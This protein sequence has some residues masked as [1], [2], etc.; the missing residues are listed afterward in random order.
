MIEATT[1]LVIW[2]ELV[3]SKEPTSRRIFLVNTPINYPPMVDKINKVAFWNI[4]FIR[5]QLCYTA[6]AE[7]ISF[8][9]DSCSHLQVQTVP[10]STCGAPCPVVTP[11][12]HY[13]L[14]SALSAI[15]RLL[16]DCFTTHNLSETASISAPLM[17]SSLIIQ[18]Y[19]LISFRIVCKVIGSIITHTVPKEQYTFTLN[20]DYL[21]KKLLYNFS[22]IIYPCKI[23]SIYC[24]INFLT[25]QFFYQKLLTS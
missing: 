10:S 21:T 9:Y 8:L 15:R 14:G 16:F 18:V 13:R 23:V 11:S 19:Y 24:N 7:V 2:K 5:F 3:V 25:F 22:L 6:I 1:H 20:F 17:L 4:V 12:Y